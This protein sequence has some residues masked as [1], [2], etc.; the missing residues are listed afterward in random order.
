MPRETVNKVFVLVRT[1]LPSKA[2]VAVQAG[3]AL[4]EFLMNHDWKDIL[5]VNGTLIYL[6]VKNIDELNWWYYKINNKHLQFSSFQEPDLNGERTAIAVI[7]KD[8]KFFKKLP[9][10]DLDKNDINIPGSGY[11]PIRSKLCRDEE[12]RPPKK[13]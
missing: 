4:A 8:E 3:H 2:Q 1:D 6:E 5:W 11:Q 12:A 10:L 13:M 9:L 7:T